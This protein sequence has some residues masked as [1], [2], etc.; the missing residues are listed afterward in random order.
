MCSISKQWKYRFE[1]SVLFQGHLR[2]KFMQMTKVAVFLIVLEPRRAS[3][4]T[5]KSTASGGEEE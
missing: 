3:S 2:G 1:D 4:H 5:L